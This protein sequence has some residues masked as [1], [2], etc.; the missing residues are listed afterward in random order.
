MDDSAKGRRRGGPSPLGEQRERFAR[1]IGQGVSNAEACR[2]VGVNRRTGTRWRFGR[3]EMGAGGL[4]I[5]YPAVTTTRTPSRTARIRSLRY[6]TFDERTSIADLHR[7]GCGVRAI[8][9]E[10][11][12][13]ASTVSRE[14]RRNA[15]RRGRYLPGA[16]HRRAC[17]RLPRPRERRVVADI[18]LGAAVVSSLE[19]RWSPEQVA[20]GLRQTFPDE[21]HRQLCMESSYRALYDPGTPLTGPAKVALRSGRRRRRPRASTTSRR[22][23]LAMTTMIGDRPAVVADRIEAGHW[24][25]DL[26]I[27]EA[28]RSAIGT[29][30]ERTSRFVILVRIADT[31]RAEAVR[32]GIAAAV[33]HLPAALRRSLTWDQGSEMALH[34]ETST[35]TGLTIYFCDPHA[36]WQRGSN[37]NMNGLLRQYLPKGSDL[38]IHTDND[39][40]TVAHEINTRPRKTLAWAT[41]A[42]LF[43]QLRSAA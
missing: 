16:A 43:D 11:G 3:T 41:P 37:E 17:A 24:E 26:I 18:V 2:I 31:R 42:D 35:L 7:A 36:P 32:D 38:G 6:L 22:P 1:L 4:T 13:S 5:Q 14:L 27:G 34:H 25:G 21:P 33:N 30:V 29:L 23:R 12:R 19:K 9:V 39:L 28:N 15:D 40:A 8:A 20:E 10:L